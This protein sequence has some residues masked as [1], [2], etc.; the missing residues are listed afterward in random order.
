MAT[1]PDKFRRVIH[2]DGDGSVLL[3]NTHGADDG[4]QFI[5]GFL[6]MELRPAESFISRALRLETLEALL[7]FAPVHP[8]LP[9]HGRGP[10]Y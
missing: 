6:H 8:S 7:V 2:Q 3:P 10:G 1:E 9:Q 4:F 5:R